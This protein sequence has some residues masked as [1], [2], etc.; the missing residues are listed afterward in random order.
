MKLNA[1]D[2]SWLYRRLHKAYGDRGWWPAEWRFEILVGAVLTQNTAWRNVE[3][4]I[5]NLRGKGW[6]SASELL[7]AGQAKVASAI[8]P[9]GYFNVKAK[10]LLNL[11]RWFVDVGGF[12]ELDGWQTEDLREA[13]LSVNGVG[14]E[15]ADDILLYAFD[16]P[17]FV[18]DAYTHRILSRLGWI[19]G[20]YRYEWLRRG[21]EDALKPEVGRFKQFHALLVAHGARTCKPKP[22]C[23]ACML[24][25]R[26]TFHRSGRD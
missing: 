23:S 25:R 12:D 26:C 5:E 19:K 9:A 2:L 16:R 21:F 1:S 11:C 6:L 3:Q 24:K 4:A 8:R 20:E 22:L 13:V 7:V 14:P 17:V 18:I 15:T 10:R